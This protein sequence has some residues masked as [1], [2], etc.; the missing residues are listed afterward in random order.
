MKSNVVKL[1]L[2]LYFLALAGT[3]LLLRN[4]PTQGYELSIY[5]H[6]PVPALAF[7]V[8]TTCV[9]IGIIAFNAFSG[10]EGK[11]WVV[12]Y[13]MLLV[14]MVVILSLPY[15]RGYLFYAHADP[16]AHW[17]WTQM[18]LTSHRIHPDNIYPILHLDL[19]N[20]SLT[21]TISPR[22]LMA[23]FP[24]LLSAM[25]MLYMY[26]FASSL[27]T[28]R[29]HVILAAAASSIFLFLTY[30]IPIIAQS[31][32][33]FTFP[34][35]MYLYFMSLADGGIKY[36][37]PLV[38]VLLGMPLTHPVTAIVLVFMLFALELIRLVH[39]RW[40]RRR[41]QEPGRTLAQANLV[42]VTPFRFT[43]PLLVSISLFVWISA[44]LFFAP[45]VRNSWQVLTGQT[46]V[47]AVSELGATAN[48]D[49]AE[50]VQFILRGYGQYLIY[51]VLGAAGA[52][53]LLRR[54]LKGQREY[55]FPF[56]F[57]V[58]AVLAD[59]FLTFL[60]VAVGQEALY[61]RSVI[62]TQ[63]V[64][65]SPIVAG[66]ALFE[67]LRRF[68]W[69]RLLKTATV[70]VV[71]GLA[72]TISF[73]ALFPSPWTYQRSLQIT[74]MDVASLQWYLAQER[75]GYLYTGLNVPHG[76]AGIVGVFGG[77][78]GGT[79]LER[80]AREL[81]RGP[82]QYQNI[83]PHFG[84]QEGKRWGEVVPYD[85]AFFMSDR[86]TKALVDPVL[87]HSWVGFLERR[88]FTLADIDNLKDDYTVD[89][90]YSNGPMSLFFVRMTRG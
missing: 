56:F 33:H 18:M 2:T 26:L 9:G 39:A 7:F 65:F 11:G 40:S 41:G 23:L 61:Y 36:R 5:A 89:K 60:N 69:P 27:F 82:H 17:A 43:L 25:W 90:L 28:D 22:V 14:N 85:I 76:I 58:A 38:A 64:Y 31:I 32:G 71:V 47:S 48:L 51:M 72:W 8:L 73:F 20:I 63:L 3:L 16:L 49:I 84:Q 70:V 62:M 79:Y 50:L 88:D 78:G 12:G 13:G 74:R 66:F 15:L 19:L 75:L 67:M 87:S 24:G 77:T 59:V 52:L 57:L 80:S 30:Q 6:T 21:T 10:K 86:F 53:M 34:L 54:A 37:V 45:Q 68:N 44:T 29:R 4:S 55:L 35:V 81:S 46:Q 83:P 1:C 42:A